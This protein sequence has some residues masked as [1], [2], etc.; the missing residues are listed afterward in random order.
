MDKVTNIQFHLEGRRPLMFDRY[1]G[2]NKTALP[3]QEKLY[4]NAD[5]H[6]TI[7]VINLFSMLVAENTK[8]VCR[9]FFGKNGKTIALG[10]SSYCL[11]EPFELVICDDDGPVKFTGFNDKISVHKA[12]ARVKGGIPNPKE[13]PLLALPWSVKG[14]VQYT[15]NP[16]CSYETLRDAFARGG[17]LGLGTFRPFFGLYTLKVF[18]RI[19]AA[20]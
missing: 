4:L 19:D 2:D 11:I 5:H 9:Q 10:I 8:S 17:A 14:T 16:Y 1:A 15:E 12:V 3:V 18:E 13:R 20:K 6:L 7:P